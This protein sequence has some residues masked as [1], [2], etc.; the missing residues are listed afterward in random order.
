[1][2]FEKDYARV[3]PFL[4]MCLSLSENALM[5]EGVAFREFEEVRRRG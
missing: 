1:V 2:N 5:V 4:R 3:L